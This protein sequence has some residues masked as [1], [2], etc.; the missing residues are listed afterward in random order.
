MVWDDKHK[1]IF[2]H[3]PKTGGSSIELAFG[4][5]TFNNGYRIDNNIKAMQHF[6]WEEYKNY[7]GQKKYD[8]YYKFTI[9]RNPYNKVISDYFWLKNI[10]K[11]EYD[12]FQNKSFDEYLDYC[13]HLVKNNLYNLTIFHDHFM[14]Q[15]KFI[16]DNNNKL[17]IDKI[18]Q[19]E[20][21]DYIENFI[22]IIYDVNIN[23]INKNETKNNII[24]NDE[25]KNKIYNIYKNDFILLKYS[26]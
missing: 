24:L 14:P 26:K 18:F 22:K 20:N 5:F 1:I 19:F 7:L 11:L 10:A 3:I 21:F 13:D 12:N 17:M 2:F 9:I 6:T 25:Q 23:H 4:L 8:E 16:Y 15:H